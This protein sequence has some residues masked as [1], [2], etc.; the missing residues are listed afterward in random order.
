MIHVVGNTGLVGSAIC[1]YFENKAIEHTGINRSNYQEYV[2]SQT[3]YLVNANGSGLKGG[4]NQDPKAD[5]ELNVASTVNL[6]FDF[7]FDTFI[8]ISSVDVYPDVSSPDTT[9][10]DSIIDPTGLQPYGFHK[11]L[12][13]LIVMRYCRNWI[14]LRLGGLVGK[15]LKKNP[16]YDWAHNKPLLISKRS[17]LTF[18]HTETV[19]ELIS[20]LIAQKITRQII[21]VCASDSIKLEDLATIADFK[22]EE[23]LTQNE[24]PVQDYDIDVNKLKGFFRVKTSREYIERYLRENLYP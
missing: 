4:A 6:V 19:A 11:Y 9:R 7:K 21:N 16:I 5:F 13:E 15:N 23:A 17:A 20:Q 1:A 12:S 22:I 3:D 24:L 10:E 8:H 2:G 18:I 14:I